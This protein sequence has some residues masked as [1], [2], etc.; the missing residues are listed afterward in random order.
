MRACLAYDRSRKTHWLPGSWFK[1]IRVPDMIN[2]ENSICF[3]VDLDLGAADIE[4]MPLEG[5]SHA[6]I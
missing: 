2:A 3:D 6:R 1:Y 4:I 5:G